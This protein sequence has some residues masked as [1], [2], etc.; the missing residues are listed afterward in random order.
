M[1][2]SRIDT[3]AQLKDAYQRVK[4]TVA[5]AAL[6][7]G[8][9]PEEVLLVA[10]TKYAGPDQIRSLVDLGQA[11][12]GENRVQQLT[13][14]AAQL[15]EFLSRK[16]AWAP[17]PD[18]DAA[19]DPGASNAAARHAATA[20][21]REVRWHMV[22]HLQRNKAR[23]VAP[24][25]RLIHSVDSLRLAEE[26]HTIGARR[27]KPIEILLQVNVS[28]EE[29][30]SGITAP[31]AP[32][33]AEQIHSMVN[34]KIRGV[35]TMAPYVEDPE[36]VRPVFVRCRELFEDIRER[37]DVGD[38]FNILSMGMSGDYPVAIEEGSN[39]VRIGRAIF[40]EREDPDH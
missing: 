25:V 40:G 20:A 4:D 28:G 23:Q 11:D 8:R 24:V 26:L 3:P 14:R 31:A 32:H 39:V 33:M 1:P 5:E 30:K 38:A 18:P 27:E 16:R 9:K 17:G 35:M 19:S 6:R 22:G 7:S 37:I 29:S 12:L 13:Q 10:V 36:Q 21:P 34:L 2:E 15:E